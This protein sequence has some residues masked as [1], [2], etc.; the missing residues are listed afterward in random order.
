MHWLPCLVD[1]GLTWDDNF[2]GIRIAVVRSLQLVFVPAPE[3]TNDK[4]RDMIW[5]V[6]AKH[7]QVALV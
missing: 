4:Y 5:T 2:L 3:K 7:C 1:Q 6:E